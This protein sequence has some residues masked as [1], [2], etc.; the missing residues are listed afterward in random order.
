MT[1]FWSRWGRPDRRLRSRPKY[2]ALRARSRAHRRAALAVSPNPVI[3]ERIGA[4]RRHDRDARQGLPAGRQSRV[5]GTPRW[6][7]WSRT[8]RASGTSRCSLRSS[9]AACWSR[10]RTATST[11]QTVLQSRNALC[12]PKGRT[13]ALD[14][15]I[16]CCA[17][18]QG[19]RARHRAVGRRARRALSSLSNSCAAE[20]FRRW[21][22]PEDSRSAGSGRAGTSGSARRR[23]PPP[24]ARGA[25]GGRT[26]P[27]RH[28]QRRLRIAQHWLRSLDGAWQ[29][30][31]KQAGSVSPARACARRRCRVRARKLE[32]RGSRYRAPPC[33]AQLSVARSGCFR[34]GKPPANPPPQAVEPAPWRAALPVRPPKPLA[35]VG[36]ARGRL[37]P[38]PLPVAASAAAAVYASETSALVVPRFTSVSLRVLASSGAARSK[39]ERSA[40]RECSS[41]RSRPA[42]TCSTS[43]DPPATLIN[44]IM[45][46]RIILEWRPI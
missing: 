8:P 32:T 34:G 10:R 22:R 36:V 1:R 39:A 12:L 33:L 24:P 38:V 31:R 13:A 11:R 18:Q 5:I 25:G 44:G 41:T 6:R 3:N 7:S 42:P 9:A 4:S 27:P 17:K 15:P 2:R 23:C 35:H 30:A 46:G 40:S 21:Q 37:G 45:A 43:M 14:H 20:T 28:H 29:A 16:S 26:S 19:W